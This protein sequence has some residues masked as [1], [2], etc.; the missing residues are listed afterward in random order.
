[1]AG[2]EKNLASIGGKSKLKE[3]LQVTYGSV[4]IIL[5]TYRAVP[6]RGAGAIFSECRSHVP[7][8]FLELYPSTHHK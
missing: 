4:R 6:R 8:P 3:T 5:Q 7:K 1:M 2:A